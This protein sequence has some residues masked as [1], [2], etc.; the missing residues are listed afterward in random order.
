MPDH[1]TVAYFSRS[2]VLAVAER[3]GIFA[4]RDLAV[5]MTPVDSS[6]H[7]FGLIRD[8]AVDLALTSPD[9]VAAYRAGVRNPLGEQLDVRI[10]LAADAGLGLAVMAEPAVARFEDLRGRR[11]GVDVPQSGF[12]L[13]LFGML[14]AAGLRAGDDYDVV[15]LGSTPQRREAL[16]RGDCAATLLNAGH[17]IAAELAGCS[18]LGAVVNR[19][20]PYLGAVLAAGG[21]W[22][23]GHV[24]IAGRFAAAWLDAVDVILDPAQRDEVTALAAEELGLPAPAAG[25]F[26]DVLTSARH[27]VVSGGAVDPAALDTVLRLRAGRPDIPAEVP[28]GLVDDRLLVSR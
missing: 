9:N 26:Y 28:A 1:L 3:H 21:A 18:R 24:E 6:P 16:L 27:G 12:A 19:Y 4:S 8:G 2:V 23:E 17:D 15:P 25:R 13:A 14:A 20:H 11:V 5:A 7:Q 10:L 22:L